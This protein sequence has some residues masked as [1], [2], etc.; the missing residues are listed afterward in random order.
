MSEPSVVLLTGNQR[1]HRWV[2]RRLASDLRLVGVVSEGKFSPAEPPPGEDRDVVARHFQ[3]RDEAE[4]RLLGDPRP[5]PLERVLG[6]THG[7][8]N[9]PEVF[10]W[11]TSRAPDFLVLYGTSIVKPPLLAAFD[12]RIVNLHLGLSPYYRGSGTNFWALVDGRPECVGATLHLAV[13][14]VDAGPIL[15]QVRPEAAPDDRI[16]ELGTRTLTAAAAVLPEALRRFARGELE[17]RPQTPGRGSLCRRQD[18]DADAVRRAW[19]NLESGMIAEYLANR[20]ERNRA[21]P[22][23]ELPGKP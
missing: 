15:C 7:A 12:G 5:L 14:K 9:S 21:C 23:V 18:F 4:Q 19:H 16:H 1:R 11:V 13:E 6:I 2:A 8:V 17:P 10:E 3:E 22:I 20:E